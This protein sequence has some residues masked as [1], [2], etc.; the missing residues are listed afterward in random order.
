MQVRIVARKLAGG[1]IE[2]ALQ[3]AQPGGTWGNRLLPQTRY[4][5]P[6]ARIDRWLVSSP[7]SV[8]TATVRIVARKLG[9][10][11]IEFALQPADADGSWGDRLLP[12][13]R[14]FPPDAR[15]DR[16]LVSSPLEVQSAPLVIP[17]YPYIT[18]IYSGHIPGPEF[19]AEFS[20][21]GARLFAG[22]SDGDGVAD[23]CALPYTRREAIARH[24]AVVTLA[25]L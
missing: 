15:I 22:D 6:D 25:N 17:I 8:E 1:R 24:N 20:L 3:P 4:F 23:V 14:Y 10:G 7:L 13:T 2:F 18:P 11:R 9:S 5:P 16:W 19:C 12:R 21:G